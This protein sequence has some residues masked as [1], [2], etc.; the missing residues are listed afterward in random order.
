M[1]RPAGRRRRVAFLSRKPEL[2]G[3]AARLGR[4]GRGAEA[5]VEPRGSY[6]DAR[7][8][9]E[10]DSRPAPEAEREIIDKNLLDKARRAHSHLSTLV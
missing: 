6:P 2:R 10:P 1:G 3:A 8:N 7:L 9:H 4:G 5:L